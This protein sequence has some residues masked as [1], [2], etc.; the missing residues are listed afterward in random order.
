MRASYTWKVRNSCEVKF[1]LAL[2]NLTNHKYR[3]NAWVGDYEYW[4]DDT[5]VGYY[6]SRAYLQQPGFNFMA[7]VSVGF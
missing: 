3:L 1:H 6:H 5:F 7:G 2:N 4:D